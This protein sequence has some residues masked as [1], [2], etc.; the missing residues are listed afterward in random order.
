VSPYSLFTKVLLTSP[1]LSFSFANGINE[2][3]VDRITHRELQVRDDGS[4]VATVPDV[5]GF[6][7]PAV[8]TEVKMYVWKGQKLLGK[9]DVG[10]Y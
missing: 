3:F 1:S 4:V 6:K 5:P 9:W 8:V 10:R 7:D 2:V